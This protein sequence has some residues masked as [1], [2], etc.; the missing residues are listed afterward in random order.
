MSKYVVRC[1][2]DGKIVEKTVFDDYEEARYY[3]LNETDEF[4]QAILLIEDEEGQER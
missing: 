3:W 1:F 4:A 2:N